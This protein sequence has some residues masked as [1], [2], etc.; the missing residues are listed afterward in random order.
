[1]KTRNAVTLGAGLCLAGVCMAQIGSSYHRAE[2]AGKF[3]GDPVQGGA[4][5]EH[6]AAP[7]YE[8]MRPPPPA[9]DERRHGSSPGTT[10]TH[11]TDPHRRNNSHV[12]IIPPARPAP[13][14]M[15]QSRTG[16]SWLCGGIG[17]QEVGFMKHEAQRYDMMLTFAARNGAYLADV[18]V[19]VID[20]DGRELVQTRCNG[21]IMLVNVP[22]K[23]AYRIVADAEGHQISRRVDV[24]AG[25][26]QYRHVTMTWPSSTASLQIGPATSG[27]SSESP[28]YDSMRDE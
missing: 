6:R 25:Q 15:V 10:G 3:P 13:E 21:P 26:S 22:R 8:R 19:T 23:G 14:M 27:S 7:S 18:Q 11:R 5:K 28:D 9:Y 16:V 17:E 20:A 1:M 4:L 24:V 12:I 2:P